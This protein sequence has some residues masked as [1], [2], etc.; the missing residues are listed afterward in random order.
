LQKRY[1]MS[2]LFISH[3]L[4]VSRARAHRVLVMKSGSIVEKGEVDALFTAPT[5]AYT[6]VLLAATPGVG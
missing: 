3:D 1:G 6:Q 4:A 5:T 2:D